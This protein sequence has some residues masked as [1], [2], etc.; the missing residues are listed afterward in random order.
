MPYLKTPLNF[1][2]NGR[3]EVVVEGTRELYDQVL[4]FAVRTE[5]GELPLEPAFGCSN[6]LFTRDKQSGLTASMALFWPQVTVNRV[7]ES[8]PDATGTKNMNI[9]YEV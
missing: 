5:N 2:D 3:A 1:R 4:F 9:D 7:T 6:S 8:E